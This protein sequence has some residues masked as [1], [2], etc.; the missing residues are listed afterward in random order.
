M[1]YHNAI[2]YIKNSPNIVPKDSSAK[3]RIQSLFTALGNPQKRIKYIRLAGNNGKSVC[4]QMMT[5]ILNEAGILSGSLTMPLLSELRENVKIGGKMISMEETLRF[6][7]QIV[8]AVATI[9]EEAPQSDTPTKKVFAP[10]AHEI[11]LCI[12]LL[13]FTERKCAIAFI[14]SE[15]STDDPSRFLPTPFS[16]IICGA[17]PNNDLEEITK[18]QSYIQRGIT[19]VVSVPQD[20]EAFKII[21]STCS[22]ANCRLTISIPKKA[23][24]TSLNLGGTKFSYKGKSYALRICG[25][26]QVTN[27]ILAIEASNVMLRNGYAIS[28]SNVEKGLLKTALPSKFEILSVAPTIIVDSTYAPIAI[29]TVCDSMAELKEFIGTK[30]RLCLPYNELCEQY[31]DALR[32]RGYS[33]EGIIALSLSDDGELEIKEELRQKITVLSTP[34]QLA[35]KALQELDKDTIL[36]IS[37][38]ANVSE[39]IRYEILSILGF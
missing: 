8:K 2:K 28:Q 35:K 1:T 29:E 9:N 16:A 27:A 13:A 7:E 37:G 23:T 15:H 38:K 21:Q 30:V 6:T 36:L 18:I 14:E 24:V 10:T 34:K 33:I 3:E 5:S 32:D 19:D 20:T 12:A 31:T 25:R 26:F 22:E 4:A 17:I 39:R 11:M